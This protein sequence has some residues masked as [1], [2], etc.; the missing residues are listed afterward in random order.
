MPAR[1]PNQ[2]ANVRIDGNAL[3]RGRGDNISKLHSAPA[4][5]KSALASFKP[6]RRIP[7]RILRTLYPQI[8]ATSAALIPLQHFGA[9]RSFDIRYAPRER[10]H[11]CE[12]RFAQ[13]RISPCAFCNDAAET[14]TIQPLSSAD[15]GQQCI[16][17]ARCFRSPEQGRATQLHRGFV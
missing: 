14:S 4:P 6:R 13:N 11:F 3:C 7:D 5:T 1:K 10:N 8:R 15:F 17:H 2:T 12:L 16:W 9:K